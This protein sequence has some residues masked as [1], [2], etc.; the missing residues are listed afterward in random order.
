[1]TDVTIY[2]TPTCPWCAKTKEFLKSLRV[3]YTEKNVVDDKHAQQEM[4]EKSGQMGV[5]VLEIDGKII[6]GFDEKGITQA[7]G[8]ERETVKK[9][10]S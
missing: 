8:K 3:K 6:V 10:K 5:P 7:L 2:T 9:K 4:I 1:M